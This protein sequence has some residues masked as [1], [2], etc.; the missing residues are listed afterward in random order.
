MM[1]VYQQVTHFINETFHENLYNTIAYFSDLKALLISFY[2]YDK[3][4]DKSTK[5]QRSKGSG[6]SVGRGVAVKRAKDAQLQGAS[7]AGSSNTNVQ[8]F[9]E[10]S[11]LPKKHS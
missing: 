9:I 4:S 5:R 10:S 2:L 6:S 3:G 8:V 1:Q 11:K 7:T